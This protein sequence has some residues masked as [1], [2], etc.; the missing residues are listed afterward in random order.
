MVNQQN[1]SKTMA[2]KAR[3]S[4]MPRMMA[5]ILRCSLRRKKEITVRM[6]MASRRMGRRSMVAKSKKVD[7]RMRVAEDMAKNRAKTATKG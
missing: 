1:D 2:K 7:M 6:D 5:G 4:N 3:K